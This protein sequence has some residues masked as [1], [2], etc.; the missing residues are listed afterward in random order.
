LAGWRECYAGSWCRRNIQFITVDAK[1][2]GSG[3]LFK[4]ILQT[5]QQLETIG[6][7]DDLFGADSEH[8]DSRYAGIDP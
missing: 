7:H 4:Q 2:L 1:K 6:G 5:S 3:I 8:S